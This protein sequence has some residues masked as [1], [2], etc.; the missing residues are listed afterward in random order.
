[1]VVLFGSF[2]HHHLSRPIC[3]PTKSSGQML[4]PLPQKAFSDYTALSHFPSS[5]LLICPFVWGIIIVFIMQVAVG[6]NPVS[7][8]N[9][10]R[11]PKKLHCPAGPYLI[12]CIANIQWMTLGA[13]SIWIYI[14]FSISILI[15]YGLR[16]KEED[17]NNNKSFIKRGRTFPFAVM[18]HEFSE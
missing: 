6:T 3:R 17:G 12:V 5:A 11:L 8:S 18:P 13:A 16:E 10:Q 1:M 15:G 2:P 14:L 9:T 7:A 4:F